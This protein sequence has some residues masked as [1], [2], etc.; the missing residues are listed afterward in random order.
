MWR[1]ILGN[2]KQIYTQFKQKYPEK[3]IGFSKFAVLRPKECGLA[4][5]SGTHQVCVCAVHVKLMMT[6]AKM[7]TLT[8]NKEVPLLHYSHALA[9]IICNPPLPSC[10]L[11]SCSCC[12][13]NEPSREMLEQHCSEAG[14]DEIDCKQWTTTD[15]S[16]MDTLVQL[17]EEF[18]DN[19]LEN[20]LLVQQNFSTARKS[21]DI[22]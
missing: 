8:R 20:S 19:F 5:A 6:N 16:N 22:S 17:K 10:H 21:G 7:A 1:L 15:R 18:L 14:I 9:E 3:K 12:P 11:G 13:G 4:G 2:V